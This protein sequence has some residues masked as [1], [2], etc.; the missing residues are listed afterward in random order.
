MDPI[1]T[2]LQTLE[3][4]EDTPL[5][6]ALRSLLEQARG[7]VSA[8]NAP[9]T[10]SLVREDGAPVKL[11]AEMVF[12]DRYILGEELGTG[13][14][15]TV[16]RADDRRL[17][18]TVALKVLHLD[19]ITRPSAMARF[20]RE[21]RIT[22]LLQHPGIVAVHDVGILQ[23]GRPFYAMREVRG[24]ALSWRIDSANGDASELRGLIGVL[25]N[26]AEAVA[27]AH[28]HGVVH[29]DLK[30]D[31]IMVGD[32]GDVAVVDWGLARTLEER[33]EDYG[34]QDLTVE[35]YKTVTGQL[36]GSPAYMPPE[37]A[38]G[39]PVDAQADVYSLGAS[40]WHVL[41]GHAPFKGLRGTDVI[42]RLMLGRVPQA[43]REGPEELRALCAAAMAP[44]KADRPRD[45]SEF[46]G[47]LRDWVEGRQRYAK[48][49]VEIE[50]A[51]SELGHA[52][53]LLSEARGLRTQLARIEPADQH[54]REER[55]QLEDQLDKVQTGARLREVAAAQHAQ[56]AL[57][58]VPDYAQARS[59]L[60]DYYATRHREA[61]RT[62][63]RAEAEQ[64]ELFL[65]TYDDGLYARYLRGKGR[66]TLVFDSHA[67]IEIYRVIERSRRMVLE[68]MASAT[69]ADLVGRRFP[70]G[71][72]LAVAQSDGLPVRVP[73]RI[74]REEH[75]D[76]V[77]P[78]KTETREIRVP[79]K[80]ELGPEERFV[81]AGW[82]QAGGDVLAA[83]S[84]PAQMRWVG[85]FVMRAYPVTNAEYIAFL[86]DLVLQG[87]MHRAMRYAP[88][89]G[90]SGKAPY[91]FEPQARLRTMRDETWRSD[92]PVLNV[93]YEAAAA[94]AAWV[95]ENTGQWW[96]LPSEDEWEKAARGV[97]GRPFPMGRELAAVRVNADRDT[98]TAV[99]VFDHEEDESIYGIFG[100]AGNART[101]C[102]PGRGQV[103]A[104]RIPIRGG[105]FA[106]DL[107]RARS[108][109]RDSA[110][111]GTVR[112]DVGIRLVRPFR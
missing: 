84:E 77:P 79:R 11:P 13:A 30:P 10:A 21:A 51:R 67:E 47:R 40:L 45:A 88:H 110:P 104:R 87:M 42:E 97:D 94:F 25:L 4:L 111:A 71:S 91:V 43:P 90:P 27:F 14:M 20:V 75:W 2:L 7:Q 24:D 49:Q 76:N 23:D 19:Y 46:A 61:E 56:A 108:A 64:L 22:G 39:E 93:T 92:S 109:A 107:A 26:A 35:G 100:L 31:N 58:H 99:S 83:N 60:A 16:Y 3:E 6:T 36:A 38:R 86:N 78:H 112:S 8:R 37:Q 33:D 32:F 105:G 29:R 95:S 48:A 34:A 52:A 66:L 17:Q 28:A 89:P 41:S 69:G 18:R 81:P 85:D 98:G 15:G 102:R 59:L 5:R 103:D 1:Q 53:S 82:Y 68:P 55:W 12:Q 62:G 73:F 63:R 96:R 50:K 70:I 57:A 54:R 106:T 80:G 101:W 72:Y 9:R 74:S 65:R 44:N